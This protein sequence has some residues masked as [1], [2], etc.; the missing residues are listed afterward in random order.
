MNQFPVR[1]ESI[2]AVTTRPIK[3]VADQPTQAISRE[4]TRLFIL[5]PHAVA[6]GSRDH[7]CAD[8]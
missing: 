3:A 6:C 7:T 1:D 2:K 5:A 8:E 4:I